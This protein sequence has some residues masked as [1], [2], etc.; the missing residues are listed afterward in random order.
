LDGNLLWKYDEKVEKEQFKQTNPYVLE[1][2]DLVNH[3]RQGKPM[4]LE[5]ETLVTASITG[6]M[7]RESA[8][9]GREIKYDEFMISNLSL[10]PEELHL[11][12]IPDF[13]KKYVP[14]KMGRLAALPKG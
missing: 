11:G 5:A 2:M 6:A 8:Y 9:T 1:H 7:G 14:P 12:N 4:S 13:E 10:M 3:I